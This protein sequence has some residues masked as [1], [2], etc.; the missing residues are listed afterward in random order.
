MKILYLRLK[1]SAGIW[2]AMNRTEVEIPLYLSQNKITM[3]F[4][5]NGKGKTVILSS[6]NPYPNSVNDNRSN[7]FRKGH[8]GE[9]EIHYKI[10]DKVYVIRH[11][12]K[13]SKIKS[14]ISQYSYEE[15]MDE[16]NNGNNPKDFDFGEE[17]NEN[18]GVRTFNTAIEE[19]FGIDEGF[20]KISRIG[21]NVTNF[22]DLSVA[23]RKK[24]ISVFLPN[25]DVYLKNYKVA[26]NKYKVLNKEIQYVADQILKLEDKETLNSSR[27]EL[28]KTID[29]KKKQLE[30]LSN[31][32]ALLV[33]EITKI[34]EELDLGISRNEF[35]EDASNPYSE[36]YNNLKDEIEKYDEFF[37]ANRVDLNK[38]YNDVIKELVESRADFQSRIDTIKTEI[39]S[40]KKELDNN[41]TRKFDKEKS[42]EELSFE[43]IEKL[44]SLIDDYTDEVTA[45][46]EEAVDLKDAFKD[47]I[48]H[49]DDYDKDELNKLSVLVSNLITTLNTYK[50]KC[51]IDSMTIIK[52]IFVKEMIAY[53]FFLSNIEDQ[54][55]HS[56]D[57]KNQ[58][59]EA[60][61]KKAKYTS[62][63]DFLKILDKRPS[64]CAIDNCSFIS[65]ALKY[66]DINDKIDEVNSDIES[67]ESELAESD[68]LLESLQ[69][70]DNIISHIKDEYDKLVK[71]TSL[72]LIKKLYKE[73]WLNSFYDLMKL[74]CKGSKEDFNK[75]KLIKYLN[76]I[77]CKE[78]IE[79]YEE[80]IASIKKEIESNTKIEKVYN[81]LKDEIDKIK[82]SIRQNN[83]DIDE[84]REVLS[85]VT[86]EFDETSEELVGYNAILERINLYNKA[87]D[88]FKAIKTDYE[89]A[90]E[91]IS[92]VMDKLSD[93][94]DLKSDKK[95]LK[96]E[97]YDLEEKLD[98]VKLKIGQLDDFMERKDTLDSE[99]EKT[100]YVMDAN[101]PTKGIPVYYI[102][103]YLNKTQTI[104]NDLLSMSQHGKFAI[105]FD[106]N[107][108][109]FFINVY[110]DN[111]DVLSDVLEASQGEMS[112]TSLSISLALMQ[113]SMSKY[114]ILSLDEIDGPLDVLNRRC[115]IEMVE[116]QMKTLNSEQAFII[117]HNNE[118]DS[119][120]VDLILVEGYD[121]I[122]NIEDNSFMSNKNIIFKV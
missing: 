27:K 37:E 105:K 24:Y 106:V 71:Q 88:D 101:N 23:E 81:S 26:N 77:S 3:L 41:M 33:S 87:M 2:A 55:N 108:K 43:E 38:D 50:S 70:A 83:Q 66:S 64:E 72:D 17:L 91:T 76:Y 25:I 120:P 20:F 19:I 18:G 102:D 118:F 80:K 60:K 39:T 99:Y 46:K 86:D 107:D 54:K 28:K 94:A 79:K 29:E 22:I 85:S 48:N 104:V 12:C 59:A 6:L 35:D 90:N 56:S 69:D 10:K 95:S 13:K 113:Q 4:G 75:L 89:K 32:I 14:F 73:D 52:S 44:N 74:F 30:K 67:L 8:D 11:Y 114:N 31:K 65:E 98:K 42:L 5:L 62:K 7:F 57:L 15:Y 112:M 78:N 61:D 68:S 49:S 9:K 115:F 40:L 117:S 63:L 93:L 1:N 92:G 109:A 111:G 119:Y 121:Q 34:D 53:S 36:Q 58:L 100:K 116:S 103:D 47:N 45:Y 84:A 97:L 82:E 16:I 96:A 21:S 122:I 51:G 110:K